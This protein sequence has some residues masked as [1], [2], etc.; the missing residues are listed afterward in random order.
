MTLFCH[1]IL[2]PFATMSKMITIL[3]SPFIFQQNSILTLTITHHLIAYFF[4]EKKHAFFLFL[5]ILHSHH[6]PP[7]VVDLVGLKILFFSFIFKQKS[8]FLTVLY[9]H[10]FPPLYFHHLG[11]KMIRKTN[12]RC[13][14]SGWF[15]HTLINSRIF[16][17][18]PYIQSHKNQR[19]L[20]LLRMCHHNQPRLHSFFLA[21]S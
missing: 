3:E 11:S 2:Q 14:L 6:Y 4:K 8:C 13:V 12:K 15:L 21:S 7:F 17:N 20:F 5:Y 1:T 16:A 18:M 9:I 10:H 19:N